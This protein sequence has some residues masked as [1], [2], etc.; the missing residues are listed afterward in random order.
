MLKRYWEPN[1][2]AVS[3]YNG[4]INIADAASTDFVWNFSD[5]SEPEGRI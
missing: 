5:G 4:S 3:S 2:T 1:S